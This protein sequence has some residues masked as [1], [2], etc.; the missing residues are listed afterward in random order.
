MNHFRSLFLTGVLLLATSIGFAQA[1]AAATSQS[2]AKSKAPAASS[3]AQSA[4][5]AP[6]TDRMNLVDINSASVD[7][8]DGIPG[9]G[10]AYAQKI[11]QGR[12]YKTKRDLV[13]KNI[14]PQ[15]VYAKV[16]DKIIAKQKK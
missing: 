13:Q 8:L 15:N 6:K 16:Q 9:I 4:S 14:L 1:P 7:E 11:V 3:T 2:S 10:P 12:P 5:A